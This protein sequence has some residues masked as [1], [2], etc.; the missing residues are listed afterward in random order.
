MKI[1]RSIVRAAVLG[2]SM[3][4]L[5]LLPS[6]AAAVTDGDLD[7][8]PDALELALAQRYFPT[9]NLHCGSFEGLA[10][11]DR[12]Q[13]YGHSVP[14]YPDSSIGKI[15][16]TAHPF[17][18]GGSDC[19]E[20]YQCIEIRYGI[21]WN[22]DLGDD[23]FGGS[24]RGDSEVYAVLLARKDTEGSQ[25]GVSWAV[26]Q[27]D[28]NQ[29]RLMKEFMSAH[30]GA[31]GDSSSY[32]GHGRSGAT[33]HQKVWSSEGK[34]AMYPSQ[35][36][37]N[38]GGYADA[39][40]CSDNR[41]DIRADVYLDVQNIGEPTVPLNRD[42][43]YPASAK[44]SALS[45]NVTYDVWSG[46]RFGDSGDYRSR[47]TRPLR[48][49]SASNYCVPDCLFREPQCAAGDVEMGSCAGECGLR[50]ADGVLCQKVTCY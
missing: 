5:A 25:W 20:P 14:G 45:S 50:S 41:C 34:H 1:H 3:T 48:W 17:N 4:V 27:N 10:Y 42:I 23:T 33:T 36:A 12:R 6:P 9:L 7:G 46:Y 2:L 44:T 35:N 32:R 13:L 40:D 38:N 8:I 39:D 28:V 43:P 15:P 47:L 37:C 21:A 24:H 26:A 30:W 19:A 16:F 49:C 18:P 11:G 29:W 31:T 22:W